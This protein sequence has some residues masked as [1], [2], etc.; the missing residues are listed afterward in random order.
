[1]HQPVLALVRI[2]RGAPR[3]TDDVFRAAL[4]RDRSEL[5]LPPASI[6]E[7]AVA[8]PYAVRVGDDDLDEYVVWER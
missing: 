7:M 2:N 6:G 4:H 8:G 1:M 3:P 5:N